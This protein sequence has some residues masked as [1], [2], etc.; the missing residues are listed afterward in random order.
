MNSLVGMKR[1]DGYPTKPFGS[2]SLQAL[3]IYRS[4]REEFK[5]IRN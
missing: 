3:R 4:R 5:S 2:D 1:V